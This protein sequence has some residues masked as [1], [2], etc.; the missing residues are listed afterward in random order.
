MAIA[1]TANG[2]KITLYSVLQFHAFQSDIGRDIGFSIC[3]FKNN[4]RFSGNNFEIII[5]DDGS[6]D[7]TQEIAEQLEKIYGSDKI[8]SCI[9]WFFGLFFHFYC[10]GKYLKS[11][12][13]WNRVPGFCTFFTSLNKLSF[14][15]PL[16]TNVKIMIVMQLLGSVMN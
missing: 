7:G 15:T 12:E 9:F 16:W 2:Q 1:R 14:C 3:S 8:V 6:P 13:N 5:I 11:L 4:S 10:I